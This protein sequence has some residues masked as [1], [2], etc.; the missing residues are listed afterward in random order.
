MLCLVCVVLVSCVLVGACVVVG[1]CCGYGLL[2]CVVC[3]VL[4][5][6]LY[7]VFLCLVFVL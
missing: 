7:C 1:L 2:Y 4:F 6:V 5:R 3:V